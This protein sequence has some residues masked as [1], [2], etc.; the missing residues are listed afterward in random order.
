MAEV[1]LLGRV[2]GHRIVRFPRLED[3]RELE[4]S[5]IDAIVAPEVF[6]AEDPLVG[7]EGGLGCLGHMGAEVAPGVRR[8]RH[9]AQ[10]PEGE[11]PGAGQEHGRRPP[12]GSV[13]G[14]AVLGEG[15]RRPQLAASLEG[16]PAPVA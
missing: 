13:E 2:L 8:R 3:Q 16:A 5:H 4:H 10:R 14:Q 1:G 11:A 15:G 9:L 6:A 12:A 7:G